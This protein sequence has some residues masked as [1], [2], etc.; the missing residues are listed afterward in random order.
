[1]K[2]ISVSSIVIYCTLL[3]LTLI[4]IRSDATDLSLSGQC[5]VPIDSICDS[6]SQNQQKVAPSSI[7]L[8]LKIGDLG[9]HNILRFWYILKDLS[10][11]Y[12]ILESGRIKRIRSGSFYWFSRSLLIRSDI[13]CNH[14]ICPFIFLSP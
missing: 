13:S 9:Q 7:M 11:L 5:S 4:A 10:F 1:M 6:A 14:S 3:R 2:L 12:I 8:W